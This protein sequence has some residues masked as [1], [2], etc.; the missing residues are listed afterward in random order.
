MKIKIG[1]RESMRRVVRVGGA[2]VVVVAA[3][4]A[5]SSSPVSAHPLDRSGSAIASAAGGDPT[6]MSTSCA[7]ATDSARTYYGYI[8]S[9]TWPWDAFDYYAW[10]YCS[11]GL[12]RFGAGRNSFI[13]PNWSTASCPSGTYYLNAG[14]T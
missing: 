10:V 2:L 1:W 11:D 13:D 3:S 7:I 12:Y 9:T 6:T 14:H 5:A 4:L 8:C